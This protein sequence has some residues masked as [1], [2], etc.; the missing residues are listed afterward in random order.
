MFNLLGLPRELRDD[1]YQSTLTEPKRVKEHFLHA[2]KEHE[3][4]SFAHGPLLGLLLTNKRVNHEYQDAIKRAELS[5]KLTLVLDTFYP[6]GLEGATRKCDEHLALKLRNVPTFEII[7]KGPGS[8]PWLCELSASE[9]QRLWQMVRL[10]FVQK[11]LSTNVLTSMS[12]KVLGPVVCGRDV[13]NTLAAFHSSL[14]ESGKILCGV[15]GSDIAYPMLLAGIKVFYE[16]EMR[17]SL[18]QVPRYHRDVPAHD[19]LYHGHNRAVYRA[20]PSPSRYTLHGFEFEL[21][22]PEKVADFERLYLETRG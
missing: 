12:L 19:L 4:F 13:G 10:S 11:F 6:P 15:G 8:S 9:V 22:Q 14:R 3:D 1:I 18:Y 16:I 20:I 17:M 5:Q 21:L 2:A 7:F